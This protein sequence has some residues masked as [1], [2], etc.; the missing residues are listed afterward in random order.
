MECLYMNTS[1]QIVVRSASFLWASGETP[2]SLSAVHA[3]EIGWK[4]YCRLLP[5]YRV[6]NLHPLLQ[7]PLAAGQILL[8]RVVPLAVVAARPKGCL[9]AP[10]ASR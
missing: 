3:E 8:D 7:G 5:P 1:V 2:T 10:I 9:D 6:V 4:H